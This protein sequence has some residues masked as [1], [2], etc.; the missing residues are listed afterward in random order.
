[1]NIQINIIIFVTYK[2]LPPAEKL[3]DRLCGEKTNRLFPWIAV[4]FMD[5]LPGHPV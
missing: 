2:A 4:C 3:A 1:M 5:F